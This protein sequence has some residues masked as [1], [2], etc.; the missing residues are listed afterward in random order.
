MYRAL[1]GDKSLIAF[2][3]ICCLVSGGGKTYIP[4]H[5][6]RGGGYGFQTNIP[7]PYKPFEIQSFHQQVCNAPQRT[8][9]KQLCLPQN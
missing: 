7:G 8:T 1:S 4:F 5:F 6:L 9:T 2:I 3:F